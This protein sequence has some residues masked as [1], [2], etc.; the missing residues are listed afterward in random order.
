MR[1]RILGEAY[2]YDEQNDPHMNMTN[3]QALKHCRIA[4]SAL[5]FRIRRLRMCQG[6]LRQP[7]QHIQSNVAMFGK[8]IFE[9][10]EF[11]EYGKPHIAA[12]SWLQRFAKI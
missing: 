2:Q 3:E 10:D 5:E 1:V 8:L 11:N 9:A 7:S 4:P 6:F 12:H